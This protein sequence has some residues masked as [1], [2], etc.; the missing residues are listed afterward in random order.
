MLRTRCVRVCCHGWGVGVGHGDLEVS[1]QAIMVSPVAPK[2]PPP[3]VP[4]GAGVG[5]PTPA[6]WC[7]AGPVGPSAAWRTCGR[8][9]SLSWAPGSYCAGLPWGHPA[10]LP[11]GACDVT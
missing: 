2:G 8:A 7:F 4:V 9:P 1:N 11:D 6:P 3:A 10:A 5:P